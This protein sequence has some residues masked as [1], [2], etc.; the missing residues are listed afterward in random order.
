MINLEESSV[1]LPTLPW[2][3]FCSIFSQK[4]TASLSLCMQCTQGTETQH[5]G[6]HTP[7]SENK[8]NSGSAVTWSFLCHPSSSQSRAS[9]SLS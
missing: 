7:L 3:P 1:L 2:E 4:H 5:W 6:Y 8:S 9:C